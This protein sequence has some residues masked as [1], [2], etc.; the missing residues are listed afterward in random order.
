[1]SRLSKIFQTVLWNSRFLAMIAVVASLV[2]AIAMFLIA[3]K[4]AANV[5]KLV[6]TYLA[7][8]DHG[9]RISPTAQV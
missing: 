4:D 6:V 7:T 9:L 3:G 8:D 2:G 1:M 5:V